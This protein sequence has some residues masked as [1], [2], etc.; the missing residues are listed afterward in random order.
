M[1]ANETEK[2]ELVRKSLNSI[3][4]E[5][6]HYIDDFRSVSAPKETVFWIV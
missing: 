1:T 6:A 4:E 3:I 2:Y 5:K